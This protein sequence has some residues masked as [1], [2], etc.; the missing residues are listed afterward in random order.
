VPVNFMRT[1]YIVALAVVGGG[2]AYFLSI[3]Q[4]NFAIGGS[5]T[6]EIAVNESNSD[7]YSNDYLKCLK[8]YT[9]YKWVRNFSDVLDVYSYDFINSTKND[10]SMRVMADAI[11]PQIPKFI[12]YSEVLVEIDQACVAKVGDRGVISPIMTATLF[13][14][15]KSEDFVYYNKQCAKYGY[16]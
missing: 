2:A 10:D 6:Q 8:D 11:C 4:N 12:S 3:K 14:R 9:E 15:L 1:L 16:K 7:F 13:E 5:V